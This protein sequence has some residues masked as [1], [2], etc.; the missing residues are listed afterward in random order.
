MG[1]ISFI[2]TY[3]VFPTLLKAPMPDYK[4]RLEARFLK[5]YDKLNERQRLAV[6][7]IEGPV[8]VIAGPGT[9]K[10]KIL[11]SRIGKILLETDALPQNIL[12]LTYTEAGVVAMR[13][14]LREM[15]GPDAYKV[16]IYTFHAFCN[17]VI[18]ENLFLFEKTALDPI[19]DLER[20]NLLKKLID[21]FPKNHPLKRYRGDAYFE[22]RN[23]D[24]LF[25]TMK[26]EGWTPA[27]ISQKI[28]EYVSDLSNRDEFIYKRKY[29]EFNVGDLKKE[30]IEEEKD[31]MEKLRAAVNE[32]D[33]FQQMMSEKK[34]YDFDDMINWVIK[35]F[36]ENKNLLA[37][38]QERF[39]YILVDEYQDT[40]GTQNRIVDLLVNYWEKP[41]VFVVGDDDQS[42]YR[43]QGANVENMLSFAGTYS[44]LLKVILVNNYRS[45]QAILDVSKTIIERNNERLV[46]KIEGLS[47]ELISSNTALQQASHRPVIKSY[48]GQRQEMIDISLQ[49]EK[50]IAEGVPQNRIGIIYRE[51]KYG[52]EL[53][54]YFKLKKIPYY[55]RRN[56]NVLEVPLAQ[57]II[58]LLKYLAAEHDIPY[59]GDE[60]LFEIL[61]FDWFHIPS[62]E[63][64]KLT[65][66]A[67][68]KKYDDTTTSLRRLLQ[69]KATTPVKDLFSQGLNPGLKNA[70]AVLEL[71]ISN[72][73]NNT[74]QI[75]F[76]KIMRKAGVL[77]YIMKSPEKI[78][79]LQVITT[80]FD[81]I[82]EETARNPYL[83][84]KELVSTLELMETEQLALPL[85]EICGNDKGVNLMT[86]HGSKG[87]EFQYIFFA[88][89]N[90]TFWE[91]KRK[92]F[93][94]F[95]LPD[96]IFSSMSSPGNEDAEELRRLFYVALTRA[97]QHL[98]ISYC[99]YKNDGT[100]LEPSMFVEEIVD[101][102]HIPIKKIFV[103]E[104]LIA[105][106]SAL[107]LGEQVAPQIEEIER[108][109][110]NRLLERFAMNVTALNNYLRCPLEFYFRNL[111]RIPSPKNEATE[112]GSSVHYALEQL[113]RKMKTNG[114]IFPSKEEFI[115]DFDWHMHRHRE[116]FTREQFDRR[117]EYGHEVLTNYYTKYINRWNKIVTIERNIRN[118]IVNGVP[119]KGKLDKLEFDGKSAN[120]VDYKTGDP[121]KAKLRLQRPSD[122]DPVGGD[123]WRQAVFYKILVENYEQKS[124]KVV[125][126]EFD[127]LEPDKKRIYKKEK[128]FI[129]PEDID[130]VCEQI[131]TVWDK[132]QDHDFYTGCG[133]Q[134]CH[135][136]NFVKTNNLAVPLHELQEEEENQD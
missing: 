51:N 95:R 96:T 74:L 94:S 41:N 79:H 112:F 134:D 135:W 7:T 117:L 97:E 48:D 29:K 1:I 108:E 77:N 46:N 115:K 73:I 44:D 84:L 49:V 109:F 83:R 80:L 107:Q 90:A 23:F 70:S 75:L 103:D 65:I 25:S 9:G 5:E 16:N 114:E 81:F 87:L 131:K 3:L 45:T 12:C 119:L 68:H 120:V 54:Q 55:S 110:V 14:R 116:S 42:I 60:M 43:F 76:E 88:G 128:I 35:A 50:L 47:K 78:W 6:D 99:C 118:V 111:I 101:R 122:K 52:D 123:Y 86:A 102:H 31:K 69:E 124:W 129:T 64:A 130:T 11:T 58:L 2:F 39:L 98:I 37:S 100:E 71:L 20:I 113:F 17:E 56:L 33:R 15:I 126:T 38:Y 106:F 26:K 89:C 63:I 18:Q 132:I 127:F 8:M 53:I 24:K 104:T 67:S 40:S 4:E 30:K 13:T 72:A 85:T 105:E 36:E 10:T 32:F 27:F 93:N 61:H 62:I 121:D 91:K 66:E 28:D 136:C 92:P 22:V 34:R 57:K 125:S 19:S 133:R 59:S 21:S 82:K